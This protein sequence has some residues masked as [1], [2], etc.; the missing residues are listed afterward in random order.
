[1]MRLNSRK[2]LTAI[3]NEVSSVADAATA[4]HLSR[5]RTTTTGKP[6][7]K[8]CAAGLDSFLKTLVSG[9][10]VAIFTSSFAGATLGQ[11]SIKTKFETWELRCETPTGEKS[12]QCALTQTV[13]AHL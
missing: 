9:V 3:G 8:L 11:G 10:F 12:E 6:V 2:N 4:R 1:M 5:A 13:K 7:M